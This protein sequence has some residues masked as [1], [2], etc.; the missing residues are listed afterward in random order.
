MTKNLKSDGFIDNFELHMRKKTGGTIIGLYYGS[1]IRDSGEKCLIS[2][3][4]I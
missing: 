1:A 3:I 4:E 2:V